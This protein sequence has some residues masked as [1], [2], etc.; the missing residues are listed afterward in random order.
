MDNILNDEKYDKINKTL[1][2]TPGLIKNED[3]EYN[4]MNNN[5][6]YSYLMNLS[7][8]KMND[9]GYAKCLEKIEKYKKQLEYYSKENIYKEIW[10]KEI[11]ELY[12]VL[13]DGFKN[14]FCKKKK[15][16]FK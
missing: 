15:A 1:I 5:A 4:I 13:K 9:E 12:I 14:G 16:S 7:Y 6:S 8:L 2:E 10:M 3:L 11:D